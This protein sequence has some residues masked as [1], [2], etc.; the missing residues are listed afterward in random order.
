MAWQQLF[1]NSSV[2]TLQATHPGHNPL[3][4]NLQEKGEEKGTRRKPFRFEPFWMEEECRGKIE[5]A[6]S[7]VGFREGGFKD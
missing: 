1:P 3:L 6:W 4:L 7:R 2:S 5:E